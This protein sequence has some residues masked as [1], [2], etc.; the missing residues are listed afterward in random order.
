V[1]DSFVSYARLDKDRIHVLVQ[2]LEGEGFSVFWDDYFEGGNEWADVLEKELTRS[3][4][5]LVIWTKTSSASRWVREEANEA[6]HQKKLIPLLFDEGRPPFGFRTIH[7]E[8]FV[9]WD[10]DK[11]AE[12]WRRLSLMLNRIVGDRLSAF[13]AGPAASGGVADEK[14]SGSGDHRPPGE[15][16]AADVRPDGSFLSTGLVLLAT[17]LAIAS[18]VYF[19]LGVLAAA[20]LIGA[21]LFFLF[22]TADRD[23][24]L[25]SKALAERW[26]LPVKGGVRIGVTEAF[27]NLFEAVFWHR[28]FSLRCFWRSAVASTLAYGLLLGFGWFF[29]SE[30]REAFTSEWSPSLRN[31]ILAF[32]V[33]NIFADYLSLFETRLFIRF[34]VRRPG[35]APVAVVLDFILTFVI[36]AFILYV[37]NVAAQYLFFVF[38]DAAVSDARAL[39]EAGG[40]KGLEGAEAAKAF[41]IPSLFGYYQGLIPQ[42]SARGGE[43]ADLWAESWLLIIAAAT[44]YV[45]SIWL[46]FILVFGAALRLFVGQDGRATVLGRLLG[47]RRRPFTAFGLVSGAFAVLVAALIATPMLLVA[48]PALAITEDNVAAVIEQAEAKELSPGASFRDCSECPEMV[49]IPGGRFRMGS[50]SNE[51]DRYDDEGPQRDVS[52]AKAFA[53]GKFEVTWAEWEACVRDGDCHAREDEAREDEGWGRG[54]RPVINIDWNDAQ[55]YAAWL[56]SKT[57]ASYRLLSEAEW[58]YAARAG[59][60]TRYAF[61]DTITNAQANFYGDAPV[62][63][64]VPVGSYPA[65]AFGLHDMH[66]NVWEWVEDAYADAYG[67]GQPVDGGAFTKGSGSYRVIRG[68]SWSNDPQSLRSADRNWITPTIRGNILGFRVARTL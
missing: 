27:N 66:G 51:P 25:P 56:S 31:A 63:K 29:I 61:G 7:A 22:R 4:A 17:V 9:G 55:A 42:L 14:R 23:M 6:L 12:C 47:V 67:A 10:G 46:V 39:G 18:A 60:P 64:T 53:V 34:L 13:T 54:Q 44:T 43:V 59:T 38:G 28:H 15:V 5:V 24:S 30:F 48:K 68:G 11:S 32:L 20:A 33:A 35:F 8:D 58:E 49:V 19:D 57:G 52:I 21:T 3:R 41:G 37:V 26:L 40:A 1:A 2:A 62:G 36:L 45:T 65:N 50:P 16:A